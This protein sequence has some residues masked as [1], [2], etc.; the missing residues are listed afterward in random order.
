VTCPAQVERNLVHFASRGG[1]DIQGLGPKQ[2]RQFL[3]AGLV[4]DAA[5]LWSLSKEALVALERQG[6]TS[7]Q[8]LLDRL[9]A[10]RRPPLDRFLYA[11]GI[12]EV[13]ER[14]AK[15][16][17]RAFPSLEAV[18][19][20]PPEALDDLDEVGPAMAQ[21]VAAWFR[22]PRNADFLRRLAAAGVQPVP[23]EA[24]SAGAF[25]G[26]TVVFTGGLSTLSRDEAKQTVEAQGGRVGSSVSSKTTLVV[27]GEAAGTKL[28][29]AKEL[30]IEIIDEPEFLRRAGRA[31]AP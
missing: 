26:Q 20:A 16:L 18:A 22:H 30:G 6:E 9:A 12:P 1:L 25:A 21:S 8:N 27:A 10:A 5:D 7:A 14:G 15:T 4:R 29:K 17:A 31:P 28:A 13:G 19:E 3:A 11:L 23:V 2:A 24:P